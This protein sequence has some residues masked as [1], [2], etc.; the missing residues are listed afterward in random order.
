MKKVLIGMII[1]GKAGGI[2]KYLMNLAMCR[3]IFS[4]TASTRS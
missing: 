3:W 1:D 4:P 2:D